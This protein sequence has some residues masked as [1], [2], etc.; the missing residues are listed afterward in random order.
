MYVLPPLPVDPVEDEGCFVM[1][2]TKD[3]GLMYKCTK[4]LLNKQRYYMHHRV[5]PYDTLPDITFREYH[6]ADFE[7]AVRS[8]VYE[9]PVAVAFTGNTPENTLLG[10]VDET[11]PVITN[12]DVSA[13]T[14]SIKRMHVVVFLK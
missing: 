14:D 11:K 1:V 10:V 3:G 13:L 5:A 8:A 9:D 2:V 12:E 7:E 4:S 6:V